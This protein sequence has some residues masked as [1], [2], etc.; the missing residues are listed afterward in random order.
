MSAMLG[1]VLASINN[2]FAGDPVRGR[3][4]VAGGE[5]SPASGQALALEGGQWCIIAGSALNDGLHRQG[6]GGLADEEFEGTV[7]P[8]RIPRDL[9]GLV[10]EIEAWQDAQD[11]AAGPYAS[12][13]FGGYSYSRATD[14]ATGL[15]MT[16]EAAFRS[17]L[18]RWR[19]L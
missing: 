19:K 12:E 9:L 15:P 3:W 16:W 14:P 8:L 17:R 2:Y 6:A 1:A 13:S 7:T 5:V 11:A 18:N 4:A 10:A